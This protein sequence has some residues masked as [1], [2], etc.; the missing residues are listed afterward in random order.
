MILKQRKLL[1]VLVITELEIRLALCTHYTLYY[2]PPTKLREGNVFTDVCQSF[3]S[4]EGLGV[5]VPLT[6][7]MGLGYYGIWLTRGR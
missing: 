5:G 2:R 6:R 3:Y 7:Y 1:F 4:Q